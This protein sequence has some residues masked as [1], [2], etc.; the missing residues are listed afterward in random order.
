MEGGLQFFVGGVS[1]GGAGEDGEGFLFFFELEEA[2]G[3][4]GP[5]KALFFSIF[6]GELKIFLHGLQVLGFEGDGALNGACIEVA[7]ACFLEVVFGEG[8]LA[9]GIADHSEEAFNF[10]INHKLPTSERASGLHFLQGFVDAR[11]LFA[12]VGRLHGLQFGLDFAD[13]G[14]EAFGG[15]SGQEDIAG[16]EEDKGGDK[17]GQ[18]GEVSEAYTQ[19]GQKSD[20][21]GKKQ[22]DHRREDLYKLSPMYNGTV[23]EEEVF[24]GRLARASFKQV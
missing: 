24:E 9:Q 16:D 13:D 4:G 17:G 2:P 23:E 21:Q 10:L 8:F 1:G 3:I 22:V 6:D 19:G 20:S 15:T 5:H 12:G 11:F 18:P 14:L 7:H